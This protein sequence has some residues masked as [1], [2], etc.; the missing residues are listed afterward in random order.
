MAIYLFQQLLDY[1]LYKK[2]FK[3][4]IS[5]L[6]NYIEIKSFCLQNLSYHYYNNF[7]VLK[8]TVPQHFMKIKNA[9][10]IFVLNLKL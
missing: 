5:K 4:Y 1:I 2:N 10:F 8:K 6:S 9:L 7:T 3:C